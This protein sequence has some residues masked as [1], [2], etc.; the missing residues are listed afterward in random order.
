MSCFSLF[1]QNNY[2][3]QVYGSETMS[4]A[5]TMFEFH[6]NITAV[7][8]KKDENGVIAD[9][10]AWHESIEVTHGFTSWFEVGAYQFLSANKGDYALRYVGNHIRP[11]LRI[12]EQWHWPLGL[13]LSAEIGYQKP[14]YAADTWT[15]EIRPIVDKTYKRVYLAFNPAIDYSLAGYGHKAGPEFSPAAKIKIKMSKTISLG[16][17]YYGSIGP[18]SAPSALSDQFHQLALVCD[19]DVSPD[20]EINFG[21][22]AGLTSATEKSIIKLILGRKVSWKRKK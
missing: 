11:R 2:E 13:S 18:I 19:L 8:F 12:P 22:V 15:L 6:T 3:I 14:R 16:I 4:A 5:T 21:Y 17:E 9:D 10:L 20:W 7:G 1:A